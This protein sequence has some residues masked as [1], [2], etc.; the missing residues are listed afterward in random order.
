[1]TS[2]PQTTELCHFLIPNA[3]RHQDHLSIWT[4]LAGP[5]W[6]R[7]PRTTD[8]FDRLPTG[9]KRELKSLGVFR[10]LKKSIAANQG[11]MHLCDQIPVFMV[12]Q[13]DFARDQHH[14]DMVTA[15][16]VVSKICST[17]R[18]LDHSDEM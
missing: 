9:L 15:E 11:L 17:V 18:C 13:Q 1:V 7:L 6:P 12:D 3:H 16:S 10:K 8:E 5:D 14:F 4:R 2:V